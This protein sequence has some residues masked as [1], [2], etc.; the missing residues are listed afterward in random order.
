MEGC[1]S[2]EGEVERVKISSNSKVRGLRMFSGPVCFVVKW[3]VQTTK[4]LLPQW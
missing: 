4:A 3:S 2:K 1:R